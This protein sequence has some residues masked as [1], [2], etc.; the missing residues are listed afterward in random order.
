MRVV[1]GRATGGL[2]QFDMKLGKPVGTVSEP[3]Q[4]LLACLLRARCA[5]AA[6]W[7]AAGRSRWGRRVL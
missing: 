7:S 2:V 6:A 5:H 4:C 3:F 1:L